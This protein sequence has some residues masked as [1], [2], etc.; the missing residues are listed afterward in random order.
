MAKS[1]S[2][3]IAGTGGR[4]VTVICH[5][6]VP[7]ETNRFARDVRV[8]E[9]LHHLG[10]SSPDSN[11]SVEDT[12]KLLTSFPQTAFRTGKPCAQPSI[13]EETLRQH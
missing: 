9:Y 2:R 6:P 5:Y 3:T 13:R 4:S 12:H 10:S 7:Q 1:K 8:W 11:A